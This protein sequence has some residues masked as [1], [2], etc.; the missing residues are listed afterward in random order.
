[1]VMANY[2]DFAYDPSDLRAGARKY[3]LELM[4]EAPDVFEDDLF[5]TELISDDKERDESE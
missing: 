5:I 3:A 4:R 2:P 1:M